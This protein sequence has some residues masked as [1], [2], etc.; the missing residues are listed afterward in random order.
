MVDYRRPNICHVLFAKTCSL[1]F[2]SQLL[3]SCTSRII[4]VFTHFLFFSLNTSQV[5]SL[6]KKNN[7]RS[8]FTFQFVVT[9][10]GQIPELHLNLVHLPFYVQHKILKLLVWPCIEAEEVVNV[11]RLSRFRIYVILFLCCRRILGAD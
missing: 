10:L 5:F 1:I 4:H 6:P 2:F 8:T 3:E 11:T 7:Y 9:F